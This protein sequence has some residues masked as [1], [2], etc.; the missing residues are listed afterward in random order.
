[1]TSTTTAA[2]S[3]RLDNTIIQTCHQ[4]HHGPYFHEAECEFRWSSHR[5]K[6]GPIHLQS[7]FI[8]T[9]NFETGPTGH[10]ICSSP[11]R[12]TTHYNRSN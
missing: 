10:S 9:P 5:P 4:R 11:L 12:L 1:M 3:P 7:N 8:I 6:T 2:T